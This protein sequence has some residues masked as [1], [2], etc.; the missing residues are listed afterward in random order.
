MLATEQRHCDCCVVLECRG[1]R[2]ASRLT[3][4][5]RLPATGTKGAGRGGGEIARAGSRLYGIFVDIV[6]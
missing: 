4:T 5:T 1:D 3:V 6:L 2:E